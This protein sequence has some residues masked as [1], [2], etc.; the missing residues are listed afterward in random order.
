MSCD[1]KCF[2]LRPNLFCTTQ[3]EAFQF[4]SFDQIL[5][6]RTKF[7]VVRR[8]I[9][10]LC[11]H[12][13]REK[14]SEAGVL[15]GGCGKWMTDLVKVKDRFVSNQYFFYA[16]FLPI[17]FL[18]FCLARKQSCQIFLDTTYQNLYQLTIKYTKWPQN[19]PN[20]RKIV[21]ISAIYTNI[22]Q[23]KILKN[24]TKL[25]FLVWK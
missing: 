24:L 10:A 13:F 9:C 6:R 7:C 15:V 11:K 4:A 25:G 1:Q 16:I 12:T 5:C 18:C 17:V 22:V 23:W 8:Q 20:G 19:I 21:Q 14:V 2:V 3:K